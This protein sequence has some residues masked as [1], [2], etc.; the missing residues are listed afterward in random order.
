ME[1]ARAEAA[2]ASTRPPEHGTGGA[3]SWRRRMLESDIFHSF[4]SSPATVAAAVVTGLAVFD[5]DPPMVLTHLPLRNPPA[6]WVNLHGHVHHEPPAGHPYINVCVD[7]T[8]YRP[9]PLTDLV[10]LAKH[11]AA[12][13]SPVG[14]TTIEQIWRIKNGE[15]SA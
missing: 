14:D 3:A 15:A 9:I 13:R 7:H 12:G 1:P 5:T 4:R 11:Q 10:T 2:T 6:G 8:D